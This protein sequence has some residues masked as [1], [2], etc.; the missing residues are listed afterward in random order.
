VF[1]FFF[2]HLSVRIWEL[3]F[4]SFICSA[5]VPPSSADE[6]RRYIHK[7]LRKITKDFV[8]YEL[9]G[10]FGTRCFPFS[11]RREEFNVPAS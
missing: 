4:P 3:F 11:F 9:P 1:A 7:F 2:L 5:D 8:T 6:D 10:V